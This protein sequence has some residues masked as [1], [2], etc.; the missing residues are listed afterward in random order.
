MNCNKESNTP[1]NE[2][3]Y[4]CRACEI[5]TEYGSLIKQIVNMIKENEPGGITTYQVSK[6]IDK[7]YGDTQELLELISSYADDLDVDG[8]H[9]LFDDEVTNEDR[10]YLRNV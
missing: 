9:E 1:F 3:P 4:T 7:D 2:S 10:W 5:Q 8:I 6:R